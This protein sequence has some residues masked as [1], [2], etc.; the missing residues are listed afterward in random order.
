MHFLSYHASTIAQSLVQE[1]AQNKF[2]M[3]RSKRLGYLKQTSRNYFPALSAV[4][5]RFN[6]FIITVMREPN[7]LYNNLVKI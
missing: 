2:E 1:F 3:L 5:P 4:R 6:Y 7:Y